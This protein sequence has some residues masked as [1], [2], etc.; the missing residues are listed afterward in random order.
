MNALTQFKT[1][2]TPAKIRKSARRDYRARCAIGHETYVGLLDI[3]IA[4]HKGC[5]APLRCEVEF[6][7][8]YPAIVETR[9]EPGEGAQYE[10]SAIRPYT[11]K[12]WSTEHDLLD[13]PEWM[14]NLLIECVDSSRLSDWVDD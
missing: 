12:K 5:G 8:A 1:P 14:E 6:Y 9:D 10:I 13:C 11:C 2:L 7:L 4:G 3:E